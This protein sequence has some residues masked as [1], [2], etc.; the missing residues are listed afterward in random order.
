MSIVTK[1]IYTAEHISLS[2]KAKYP[3]TIGVGVVLSALLKWRLSKK[4]RKT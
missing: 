2:T 4:M 1:A 3:V